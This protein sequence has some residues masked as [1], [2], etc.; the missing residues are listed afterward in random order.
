VFSLD[1]RQTGLVWPPEFSFTL[2]LFAVAQCGGMVEQRN[3]MTWKAWQIAD[4]PGSG[5]LALFSPKLLNRETPSNYE[6]VTHISRKTRPDNSTCSLQDSSV[7][8]L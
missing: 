3:V 8:L 4:Y 5:S 2:L 7:R 1:A 6:R